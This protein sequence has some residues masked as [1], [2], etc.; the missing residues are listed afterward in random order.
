MDDAERMTLGAPSSSE[1]QA[2]AAN[3][4][5]DLTPMADPLTIY[6]DLCLVS[7]VWLSRGRAT[8][9]FALGGRK[10]PF[11]RLRDQQSDVSCHSAVSRQHLYTCGGV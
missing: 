6:D 4:L 7:D 5:H 3:R 8:L 2:E 11:H 1:L 10:V 9:S